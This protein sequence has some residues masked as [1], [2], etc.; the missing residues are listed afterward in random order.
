MAFFALLV[1]VWIP[2]GV[3]SGKVAS[4]KDCAVI[5]W[6]LAGFIFG[7]LGLIGAAGLPDRKL[8]GIM[9]SIAADLRNKC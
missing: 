3:I 4:S 9:K 2:C 8:R 7:P 6:T 5:P 1:F